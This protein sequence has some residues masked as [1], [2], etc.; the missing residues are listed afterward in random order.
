MSR[1]PELSFHLKRLR[2]PKQ[3]STT[4]CVNVT[5]LC[6][7]TFNLVLVVTETLQGSIGW[8]LTKLEVLT[9]VMDLGRNDVERPRR[10]GD[11]RVERV[12]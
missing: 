10:E 5:L 4:F 9:S 8:S 11:D 2:K 1:I 12:G 6:L 7:L 3:T